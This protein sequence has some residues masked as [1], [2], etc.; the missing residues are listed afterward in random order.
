MLAMG[1]SGGWHI[2]FTVSLGWPSW[3]VIHR[4]VLLV[5]IAVFVR[6]MEIIH[7]RSG[8][9]LTHPLLFIYSTRPSVHCSAPMDLYRSGLIPGYMAMYI[10]DI[11]IW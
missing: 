11:W 8:Y 10:A 1:E 2:G 7:T 3:Y 4:G 5:D 6:M 9:V